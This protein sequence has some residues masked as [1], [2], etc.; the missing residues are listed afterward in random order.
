M[1]AELSLENFWYP[2]FTYRA[3]S[4]KYFLSTAAFFMS[5]FTSR[6]PGVLRSC[7]FLIPNTTI[8][9]KR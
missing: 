3:H 7:M 8:D 5:E 2:N 4:K 6:I 1:N 9:G